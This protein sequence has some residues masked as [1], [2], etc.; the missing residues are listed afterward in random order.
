MLSEKSMHSSLR[1]SA[2]ALRR[3][4]YADA[5]ASFALRISLQVSSCSNKKAEILNWLGKL[6]FHA[7]L[8]LL[9]DEKA[10]FVRC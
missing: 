1:E 10:D 6:K 5:S 3:M 7:D 4:L 2:Y 9:D 8:V